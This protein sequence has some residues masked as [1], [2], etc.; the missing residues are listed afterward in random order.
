MENLRL[1]STDH[2]FYPSDA[3]IG[4]P[5]EAEPFEDSVLGLVLGEGG[6]DS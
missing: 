3:R 1:Y 5:H 6:E 4:I 2:R